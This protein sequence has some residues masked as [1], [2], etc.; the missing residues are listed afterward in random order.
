MVEPGAVGMAA[1]MGGARGPAFTLLCTDKV[2][3]VGDPIA[4]V[5]AESR[6]IAEDAIELVEVDYDDLPA[7]ASSA[8][9]RRSTRPAGDLR[10][11][12]QQRHAG[13]AAERLRRC[14]GRLRPGRPG[15]LGP[16]PPAPSPERAHGGPGRGGVVRPGVGPAHR[17]RRHPGRAHGPLDHGQAARPRSVPGPGG[18]R[19]DRWL[20]RAQVRYQP[21]GDRGGGRLPAPGRAG[22]VD[23]GPQR[24]PHRLGP[25]PGGELRGGGGGHQRRRRPRPE[26]TDAPRLR[27]LPGDGRDAGRDH[28]GHDPRA[29]QDA[30]ALVRVDGGHH[31]QGQLRRLPG[32]VGGRDV[33]ARAPLRHHRRRA[34]HRPLRAASPQR[35]HRRRSPAHDGDRSAPHRGHR[36]PVPRAHGPAGRL[37][38]VPSPPGRRPG[39][40]P[41]P[42]PGHRRLP[43]VSPRSP[44]GGGPGPRLRADPRS[45]GGRRHGERVHRSDAPRPGPPDHAGPD[46]R[47]R[48]RGALRGRQGRRRRHRRGA[49]RHDRRESLGH[50]GRG[51]LAG[52]WPGP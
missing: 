6:S 20:V 9:K 44:G 22:Q 15:D 36:P 13:G 16:S 26:G 33:G 50:P 19:G 10:G 43:R 12:G 28:P 17:P 48:V 42:R 25:G 7:V 14:R 29:L 32:P 2:R 18:G 34:R 4:L 51:C 39:R 23:R 21:G 46:R 49:V 11:P 40:G 31:Q 45:V 3:F 41:L 35:G 8:T 27:R 1:A 37:R 24:E 5:V 30:G 38:R 52:P 47:R